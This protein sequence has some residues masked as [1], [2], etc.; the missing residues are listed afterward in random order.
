MVFGF[1][2]DNAFHFPNKGVTDAIKISNVRSSLAAFTVCL[3]MNSTNT[4]GTPFSY[5][6]GSS[7]NELLIEHSGSFDFLIGGSRR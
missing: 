3:W 5:A 2:S 4:Q 1:F 6:V 7:D